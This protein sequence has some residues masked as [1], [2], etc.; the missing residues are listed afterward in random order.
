MSILSAPYTINGKVLADC[1]RDELERE[2]DAA[3]WMIRA[4]WT[5]CY[6]KLEAVKREI[7]RR[8][9]VAVLAN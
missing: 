3:N 1:S 4:G 2:A 8:T 7:S 9:V 6:L 5:G